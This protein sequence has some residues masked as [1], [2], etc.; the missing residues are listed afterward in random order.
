MELT[1]RNRNVI[2]GLIALV[3]L[4]SAIVVSVSWS[5]GAFDDTYLLKG[6]FDAA[7]Q[8]LS[9]GSDVKIRGVNVGKVSKVDLLDGRAL[10]TMDINTSSEIPESA[11]ATIRAKTLFGEKFVDIA[12]GTGEAS[13]PFYPRTGALLDR[14]DKSAQ[15]EHTCTTGGF[16]LEKVLGDAYPLLKKINPA[17]LMTVI[18]TLAEAGRDLGPNINRQIVNSEKVLDVNAAHD[19]DTRQFLADLAKL[20][21][22]LGVRADDLVQ[23]ADS[24][25]IALPTLNARADKLNTLLAQTA[26]LSND[27]ADLLRNNKDFIDKSFG[28]GQEV[29]NVVYDRRNDIV[30]L[31]IGLREY[32]QTLTEIT[33][34]PTGTD[35]TLMAAVKSLTCPATPLTCTPPAS[36]AN[37]ASADPS[38]AATGGSAIGPTDAV[39]DPTG[40]KQLFAH[41]AALGV[42]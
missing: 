27:V 24:L 18:H 39:S 19:A 2:S 3:L 8:G 42:S 15:P 11:T 37:P 30:P 29:L 38:S 7:G 21:Q 17:E 5:F 6:S 35:G 36:A 25:N 10:V 34:I 12:P 9:K 32:L 14:C 16:E 20:A 23:A 33:R 41:L 22:Q 26:R 40:V 13:G 31:V 1:I 4:L 28:G